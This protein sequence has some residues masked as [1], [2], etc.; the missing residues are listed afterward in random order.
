MT[1]PRTLDRAK[2]ALL[3]LLPYGPARFGFV[4]LPALLLITARALVN[5]DLT[6]VA[7]RLALPGVLILG[8][9]LLFLVGPSFPL[10]TDR[11]KLLT[12]DTI[13]EHDRNYLDR[14]EAVSDYFD[15]KTTILVASEW[16][17][18]QYHLPEYSYQP[19]EIYG[20]GED[21]AG[22]SKSTNSATV[23]C[24]SDEPR[25]TAEG[26]C[27]IVLFDQV[28]DPWVTDTDRIVRLSMQAGSEMLYLNLNA[29]ES[30]RLAPDGI[31]IL[32]ENKYPQ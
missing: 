15:P 21:R 8:S 18:L 24:P 23:L 31:S 11:L 17:F 2:P 5:L 30:V 10:G 25:S 20:R 27:P 1:L 32:Y 29:G 4:Y 13:Q 19:Y 7:A 28:L 9:S 14:I 6:N 16:R 12:V 3:H 22:Q 26:V